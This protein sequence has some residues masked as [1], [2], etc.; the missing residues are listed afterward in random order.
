MAICKSCGHT[1][2][3]AKVDNNKTI[4]LDQQVPNF[5]VMEI[6]S[7]VDKNGILVPVKIFKATKSKTM[8]PHGFVCNGFARKPPQEE[9][10]HDE[11]NEAT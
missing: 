7:T 8:V 2:L 4:M 10:F 5:E 3:V 9:I 6:N 11:E 1:V